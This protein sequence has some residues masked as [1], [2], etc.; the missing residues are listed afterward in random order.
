LNSN[1]KLYHLSS[2]NYHQN[3]FKVKNTLSNEILVVTPVPVRLPY[4]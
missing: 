1:A 3:A 4:K 2:A